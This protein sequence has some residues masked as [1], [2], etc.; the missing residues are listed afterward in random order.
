MNKNSFLLYSRIISCVK[1]III[2]FPYPNPKQVL[3]GFKKMN[4]QNTL[5][6]K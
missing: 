5:T 4:D 2:E 3:G 6:P 1:I